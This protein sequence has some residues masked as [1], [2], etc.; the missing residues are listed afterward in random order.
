MKS[1]QVLGKDVVGF[2]HGS[3]A[4][5]GAAVE[6]DRRFSQRQDPSDIPDVEVTASE[7]TDGKMWI[8]QLLVRAGLSKSN[9]EARRLL[10]PNSGVTI[11][12]EREKITDAT[13]S[14]VVSSG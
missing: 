1:K 12:E 3:D 8:C 7:L 2:Y 6:W 9:N 13:T 4:A 14:V 11:G 5:A 10:G